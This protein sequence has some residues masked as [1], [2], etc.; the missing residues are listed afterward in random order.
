MFSMSVESVFC[1]C[2][3]YVCHIVVGESDCNAANEDLHASLNKLCIS[4]IGAAL[5]SGAN[6]P[7]WLVATS[8]NV[9]SHIVIQR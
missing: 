7:L 4:M 2:S 1:W 8:L 3:C 9:V 5:D 6:D